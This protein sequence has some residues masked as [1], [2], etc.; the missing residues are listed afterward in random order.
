MSDSN[1]PA[2][3]VDDPSNPTQS[4]AE[5]ANP[6]GAP[7]VAPNPSGDAAPAYGVPMAWGRRQGAQ[8]R[9]VHPAH[10]SRSASTRCSGTSRPTRR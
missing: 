9:H 7:P 10:S 5:A 8:H 1:P 3:P 2:D 6:Y 4:G